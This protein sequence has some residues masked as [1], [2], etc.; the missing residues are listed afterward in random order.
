MRKGSIIILGL[1][2]LALAGCS[3]KNKPED[4]STTIISTSDGTKIVEKKLPFYNI[5]EVY[6]FDNST[7]TTYYFNDSQIPY[8]S[9]D[10][11]VNN[12]GYYP[13]GVECLD[14]N[15]Y[16][17]KKDGNSYLFS[18][19]PE[20][21][22]ITIGSYNFYSIDD[23]EYS[24]LPEYS[25]NLRMTSNE[26]RDNAKEDV[27]DISKYNL[28]IEEVDGKAVI[29]FHVVSAIF[30]MESYYFVNYF[31]TSYSGI[32]YDDSYHEFDTT[33]TMK[34][35]NEYMTY[36][37]NIL[38][39]VFNELYGLNGYF[40][41]NVSDKLAEFKTEIMDPKKSSHGVKRFIESLEDLHS[42]IDDYDHYNGYNITYS[43]IEKSK[44]WQESKDIYV[45]CNTQYIDNEYSEYVELNSDTALITFN[46]FFVNQYRGADLFIR[47]SMEKALNKGIKNI[48]FNVTTNGG[49]DT[50][51]LAKI[52]GLM[53][54]DDIVFE[55]KNTKTGLISQEI[56]K[57][58]A[59]FDGSY[60]DLD[61]YDFNYY[62]LCSGYTFSC[63]NDF[64]NYCKEKKMAKIIGQ[65]SGGGGCSIAPF[66]TP[67]CMT[68]CIS[69]LCGL[70]DDNNN[71]IELGIDVDYEIELNKIL[72][73]SEIL[74][75]IYEVSKEK[76]ETL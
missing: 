68:L 76:N 72:D 35:T 75:A 28:Y 32:S 53:T 73:K 27:I 67:L 55:F 43:D 12:I 14:N 7:I 34:L 3:K 44:R 16:E 31:G 56:F 60:D 6:P 69:S 46:S 54:N 22:K 23:K 63:A 37:Y 47:E 65:K 5:S 49:G 39:F 18:V 41:F 17:M 50:F 30:S 62:I 51:S 66:T 11:Y 71:L 21:E 40:D 64:V 42:W 59:D 4:I 38:D 33:P 9:L 29:P 19:N 45:T 2:C 48:V 74:N 61:A 25:D 20:E 36:N 70:Y 10:E 24:M 13:T 57:C 1:A 52:L 8:I 58:D 26:N 15:K